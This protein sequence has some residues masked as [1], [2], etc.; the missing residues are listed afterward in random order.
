METGSARH[1][2]DLAHRR[3]IVLAEEMDP[4]KK[5][6]FETWLSKV[7]G[8]E[9]LADAYPEIYLDG[10]TVM[11]GTTVT[12]PDDPEAAGEVVARKERYAPVPGEVILKYLKKES[13]L[14]NLHQRK[15]NGAAAFTP[16]ENAFRMK[17]DTEVTRPIGHD[18]HSH[19][20]EAFAPGENLYLLR[21]GNL[22]G[23][24]LW[25]T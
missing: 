25:G 24:M 21:S 2:F 12:L 4:E 7:T 8:Y 23:G 1:L 11:L 22:P 15:W 16:G 18:E 14:R 19:A 13:M 5:K 20:S 10:D 3:E 17:L 9:G 6:A